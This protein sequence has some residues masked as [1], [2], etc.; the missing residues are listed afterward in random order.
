MPNLA[1]ARLYV[2]GLYSETILITI[3]TDLELSDPDHGPDGKIF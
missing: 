1:I 2:Y 3:D